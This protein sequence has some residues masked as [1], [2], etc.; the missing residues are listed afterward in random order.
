MNTSMELLSKLTILEELIQVISIEN[1]TKTE[2]YHAYSGVLA[3]LREIDETTNAPCFGEHSRDLKSALL[4]KLGLGTD[5]QG[6]HEPAAYL[7][8]LKSSQ[9][10]DVE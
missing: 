3:L 7:R 8:K 9:C 10:L 2:K 4:K 1:T 5:S 6:L